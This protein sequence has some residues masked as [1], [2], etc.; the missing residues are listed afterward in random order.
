MKQH[1]L[2]IEDDERLG[3]LVSEYLTD[4]GFDIT[5][6]LNATDGLTL[7]QAQPTAERPIDG[8]ILD[9]MLPDMDGLTVCQKVRA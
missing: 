1:L 9:L 5:H 4:A 7:V 3:A 8:I 6:V 2:L